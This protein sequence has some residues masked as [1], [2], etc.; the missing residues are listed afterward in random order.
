MQQPPSS[1]RDLETH[2]SPSPSSSSPS[3]QPQA[4]SPPQ[5]SSSEGVVVEKDV[6]DLLVE[7]CENE[8]EY[9]RTLSN[10]VNHFYRPFLENKKLIEKVGRDAATTIFYRVEELHSLHAYLYSA[11]QNVLTQWPEAH[12]APV[13]LKAAERMGI[14]VDVL[15]HHS[16][17][18]NEL[19]QARKSRNFQYWLKALED[20]YGETSKLI[21]K[22]H[23]RVSVYLKFLK[24]VAKDKARAELEGGEGGELEEAVG[25]MKRLQTLLDESLEYTRRQA[26]LHEI[27]AKLDFTNFPQ[28]IEKF[29]LVYPSRM[30]IKEGPL[31]PFVPASPPILA[32]SAS[33]SASASSST[34]TSSSMTSAASL[35]T[36][37]S[38]HAKVGDTKNNNDNSDNNNNSNTNNI[39]N[40]INNIIHNNNNNQTNITSNTN[41]HTNTNPS[42]SYNMNNNNYFFLFNDVLIWTIKVTKIFKETYQVKRIIFLYSIQKIQSFPQT[43]EW[44]GVLELFVG[45]EGLMFIAPSDAEATDWL[46]NLNYYVYYAK[47]H[48]IFGLGLEELMVSEREY[49]RAVPTV[50]EGTVEALRARPHLLDT[51]GIFRIAGS[52]SAI[53][54][55]SNTLD[56]GGKVD[57]GTLDVHTLAGLL[58]LWLRSLPEPLTTCDLYPAFIQAPREG[59][60][61]AAV[62]ALRQVVGRLPAY[63]KFCLHYILAFLHEVAS[64]SDNNKM[65]LNNLGIVFGPNLLA[66]RG[67]TPLDSP[68]FGLTHACVRLLT[69]NYQRIFPNIEE[70]KKNF[71]AEMKQMMNSQGTNSQETKKE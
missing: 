35:T 40:A 23:E 7:L 10:L 2:P 44:R 68:D 21:S 8:V 60:E 16:A 65:N 4:S 25:A 32:A 56:S 30:L 63:N 37:N 29:Q 39:Y 18:V 1:P 49:G 28:G 55:L 27:D 47:Q 22:S 50:V 26:K 41:T 51:E 14:F 15:N 9:G 13:F 3:S 70:E 42:T 53:K 62:E 59:D 57:Y 52:A 69:Q 48:K 43:E 46:E 17:A 5:A 11:F 19:K 54:A 45:G 66:R 61:E 71:Q 34:S 64:H 20:K 36:S 12:I 6:K 67:G 38:D 24:T 33:A 31:A 58:K